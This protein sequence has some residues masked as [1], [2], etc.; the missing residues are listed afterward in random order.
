[1]THSETPVDAERLLTLVDSGGRLDER[2]L[3]ALA[4]S[5]DI[6]V[7]GMMADVVRRR[8]HGASTTF[9]RVWATSDERVEPSQV[10]DVARELRAIRAPEALA[11]AVTFVTNLRAAARGRTVTG[12]GW[13]DIERWSAGAGPDG[14]LQAL[15]EAG[16]DGL[17]ELPID[18]RDSVAA[19]VEPM[20]RLGFRQ[21]RLSV[22]RPARSEERIRQLLDV[23]ARI[24]GFPAVT[25][26]APLPMTTNALRPTTGYDD[27]KAV[28]LA[29]LAL[30]TVPHV[31]VDWQRYGPKLAQV[32][33]TFGAD[34]VDNVSSSDESPEGRRRAPIEELRRNIESAGLQAVERDGRFART[35]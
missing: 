12:F 30:P 5:S 24:E 7:L 29:R 27:V 21:I 11:D 9:L 3:L 26:V 6:L 35:P 18:E 19:R 34:D 1:M 31:Q 32:A 4:Q 28:A 20:V 13:A 23:A 2:D 8:L 17:S 25:V 15:R 10:P 16:L 14:V 22:A 33:L